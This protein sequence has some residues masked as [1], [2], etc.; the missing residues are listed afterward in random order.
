[1]VSNI[2]L[3]QLLLALTVIVGVQFLLVVLY[4]SDVSFVREFF[5]LSEWYE[6]TREKLTGQCAPL[7]AWDPQ[8]YATLDGVRYPRVISL[9]Q[10][11]KINVECLNKQA[12]IKKILFWNE[13][14][15][16]K[17]F[18]F[19]V[20][21]RQP[22]IDNNCP[23]TSCETHN[24]KSRLNESD[25]VIMSMMD[26]RWPL[27]ADYRYGPHQRWVFVH[28]ESPPNS[29]SFENFTG[30]FNLTSTY[31]AGSDFP[32][33]YVAQSDMR[34]QLNSSF[35]PH[36]DYLTVGK[37]GLAAAVISNCGAPSRRMEYIEELQ[38]YVSVD[39]FGKCGRKCPT[40]FRHAGAG[41]R[42]A[43]CNEI[44]ALEYK[45]YLAFENSVCGEYITEKFFAMLRKPIVP[46]VLGGGNYDDYV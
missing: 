18:T 20:G 6:T 7:H 1:M 36:H 35:D 3:F 39:V 33:F 8:Y 38:K 27:P 30:R 29:I 15:G 19:G 23:V 16:D 28:M 10:D 2:R 46:I 40:H 4:L 13:F 14:T 41:G 32:V 11:K 34:W 37:I 43:D 25:L 21:V 17:N 12:T 44:I 5:G 42:P 24:N 22:F 31:L 26:R 45:F 9:Y